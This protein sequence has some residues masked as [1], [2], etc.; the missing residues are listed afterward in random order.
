MNIYNISYFVVFF[1]YGA[2]LFAE[3]RLTY[4][5]H[6]DNIKKGYICQL[7]VILPNKRIAG[8]KIKFEGGEGACM[9]MSV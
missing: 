7:D 5:T 8:K 9:K 3:K 2:G 6:N 4:V 1:K